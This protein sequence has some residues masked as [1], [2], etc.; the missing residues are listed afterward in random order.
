[1]SKHRLIAQLGLLLG[2]L[3]LVTCLGILLAFGQ[4]GPGNKAK[5]ARPTGTATIITDHAV[6][7]SE[8]SANP[9]STPR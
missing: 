5:T 3:V 9:D 6:V 7:G 8:I 4:D 1:M 2:G